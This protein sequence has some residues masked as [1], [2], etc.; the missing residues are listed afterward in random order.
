MRFNCLYDTF[1]S[2]HKAL[3]KY[4]ICAKINTLRLHIAK[5]QRFEQLAFIDNPGQ[6]C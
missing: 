2:S 6:N 3:D 1:F 5:L 4:K